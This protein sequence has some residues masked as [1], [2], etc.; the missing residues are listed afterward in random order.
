MNNDL[1][2][3]WEMWEE[4]SSHS[5]KK[6]KVA[7]MARYFKEEP[8]LYYL[9]KFL[10]NPYIVTNLGR[11]SLDKKVKEGEYIEIPDLEWLMIFLADCVGDDK[12]IRTIQH[13]I[14]DC[15]SKYINMVRSIATKTGVPLGVGIKLFNEVCEQEGLDLCPDFGVMLA[16][17]LRKE[18]S[19]EF[20]TEMVATLKLDGIR[21]VA[22]K[23]NSLLTFYTRKGIPIEGL[24]E[25]AKEMENLKDGYVYDGELL[26]ENPEGLNSGDLFRATQSVV[27]S[28]NDNKTG[29]EFHMFDL[30]PVQEFY[31]GISSKSYA[32]RREELDEIADTTHIIKV[33]VLYRGN[34]IAEVYAIANRL[35]EAGSEGVIVNNSSA[36]YETKRT[37]NLLKVKGL[38]SNDG[39]VLDFYKGKEGTKFEN[40]LGGMIVTYKEG[41]TKVGGAISDSLRDDIWNNKEKYRGKVVEYYFSEKSQN[42]QGTENVRFGRLKSFRF[43]KSPEDVNYED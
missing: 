35:I 34:D 42:A 12:D 31:N 24:K 29:L 41:T 19:L 27:R 5:G 7:I 3:V 10:V 39:V 17:D 2:K 33:P 32:E 25:L 30:L 9:V 6:D 16:K 23:D 28:K 15:D 13:M 37:K 21:C 40:T 26:L 8:I 38:Y 14:A 20:I 18:K 11:K 1:A 43:D 22:I 4:L 36:K